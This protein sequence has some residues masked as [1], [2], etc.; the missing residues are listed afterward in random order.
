VETKVVVLQSNYLPWKGYF[1]L[2]NDADVFCFYDE[3]KYTKNDWRN[4]NKIYSKNGMHWL[5]ISINK[6]AVKY[7]I[8]EAKLPENWQEQHY[9]SLKLSYGRAPFYAQL[10]LIMDDIYVNNKFETLSEFNQYSIQVIAKFLGIKTKFV[11]SRDYDL[12]GDRLERLINLL[13]DLKAT[14]YISGPSA[15]DYLTGHEHLFSDAGIKLTYKDYSGYPEYKQ[16]TGAFENYV[17]IVDLI[18]NLSG[19]DIRKHIWE[20]RKN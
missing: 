9:T 11:N 2:I 20:W 12:K 13:K 1:D 6:D 8:S 4:R 16:L 5:S 3:V 15:K 10:K 19:E 17:S 14:E 7:K 18:A